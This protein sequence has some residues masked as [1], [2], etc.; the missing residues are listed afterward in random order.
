MKIVCAKE[1]DE[2]RGKE[3]LKR[4][5]MLEWVGNQ[6]KWLLCYRLDVWN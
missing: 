6:I 4:G 2:G 1:L 5:M 3:D